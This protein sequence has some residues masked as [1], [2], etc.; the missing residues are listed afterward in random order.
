MEI[1]MTMGSEALCHMDRSG[2]TKLRQRIKEH[3]FP[4]ID[5]EVQAVYQ[6]GHK[7]G[8]ILARQQGEPM[9]DYTVRRER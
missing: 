9:R 1:A 4:R 2:L 7:H 6:G 3:V 8:G 5:E